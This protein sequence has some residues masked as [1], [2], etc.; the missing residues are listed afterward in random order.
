MRTRGPPSP[1]SLV[2]IASPVLQGEGLQYRYTGNISAW[3]IALEFGCFRV[4][5]LL[6][7]RYRSWRIL[8]NDLATPTAKKGSGLRFFDLE[9]LARRDMDDGP[10]FD[11][12]ATGINQTIANPRLANPFFSRSMDRHSDKLDVTTW[13]GPK[14]FRNDG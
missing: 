1:L 14:L 7:S 5:G 8:G 13:Q 2:R 4:V 9:Y 11:G 12:C 3:F 10:L 6:S